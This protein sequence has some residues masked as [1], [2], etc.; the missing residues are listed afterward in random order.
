MMCGLTKNEIKYQF[1]KKT[2]YKVTF[3]KFALREMVFNPHT[4]NK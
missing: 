4:S 2:N 1:N 3:S